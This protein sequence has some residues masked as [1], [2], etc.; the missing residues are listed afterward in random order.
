LQVFFQY[1]L[2]F[3]NCL[4]GQLLVG[5]THYSLIGPVKRREPNQGCI[6]ISPRFSEKFSH[7]F[8]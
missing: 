2:G 8:V 7:I 6:R 4:N 3:T 5:H 1:Q